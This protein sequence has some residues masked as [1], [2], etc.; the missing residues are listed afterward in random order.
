MQ[1]SFGLPLLV[2]EGESALEH[3]GRAGLDVAHPHLGGLL[4]AELDLAALALLP[5]VVE[6]D[7]VRGQVGGLTVVLVLLRR[8]QLLDQRQVALRLLPIGASLQG[9]SSALLGLLAY[10]SISPSKLGGK[11]RGQSQHSQPRR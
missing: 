1:P 4:G 9:A 8:D 6:L 5:Q 7:L 11:M 10:A 2:L 3:L